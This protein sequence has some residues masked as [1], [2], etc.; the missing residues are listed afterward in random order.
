MSV[1]DGQ[2]ANAATFNGAYLSKDTNST[3]TAQ[4]S[5]NNADSSSGSSVTNI[6]REFNAISS[7]TGKSLNVAKD[8]KPTWTSSDIGASS[9]SLFDRIDAVTEAIPVTA[10]QVVYGNASGLTSSST[11]T[12]DGSRLDLNGIIAIGESN[13]SASGAATALTYTTSVTRV[14][15]ASAIYGVTPGDTDDILLLLNTSGS[16]IT[17]A[18]QSASADASAR[19][20]TGTDADFTF[21][22]GSVAALVRDNT[23]SRWRLLGGGGSGAG[24]PASRNTFSTASAGFTATGESDQVWVYTG[25]GGTLGSIAP[26]AL[27]DQSVVEIISASGTLAIAHNDSASGIFLNGDKELGKYGN[28]KLRWDSTFSRFIEVSYN[29]L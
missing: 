8:N 27:D 24:G 22:N 15:A 18:N 17:M 5:L 10:N 26:G 29:G 7:W 16:D 14:T 1:S 19:I 3:G 13:F 20:V 25:S 11:L 2:S 21:T 4:Y 6:Q 9:N 23:S 28:V 12:F